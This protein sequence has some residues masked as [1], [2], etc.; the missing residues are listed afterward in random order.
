MQYSRGVESSAILYSVIETAKEDDMNPY[1][2]LRW[3]FGKL[4]YKAEA[5]ELLLGEYLKEKELEIN[6]A[7]KEGFCFDWR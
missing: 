7:S 2:Y 3:V 6:D 1:E 5:K 4:R